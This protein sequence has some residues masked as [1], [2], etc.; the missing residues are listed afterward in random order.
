MVLHVPSITRMLATIVTQHCWSLPPGILA[1]SLRFVYVACAQFTPES[2]RLSSTLP[3]AGK[4]AD[5]LHR[6]SLGRRIFP[7]VKGVRLSFR[8]LREKSIVSIVSLRQ[9]LIG[10]YQ[11]V[12][13]WRR[14]T[15]KTHRERASKVS[16]SKQGLR[17]SATT[18]RYDG[19]LIQDAWYF[20]QHVKHTPRV[21]SLSKRR[22]NSRRLHVGR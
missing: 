6:S 16:A 10:I 8:R 11:N 4:R 3:V 14:Y 5:V 22:D 9:I 15:C 7:S 13:A 17:G 18:L 19:K 1:F 12:A 21:F 20:A 2:L